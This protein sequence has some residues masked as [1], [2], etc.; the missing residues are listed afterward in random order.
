M[1]RAMQASALPEISSLSPAQFEVLGYVS[2]KSDVSVKDIAQALKITPSA[3][4]QLVEPLVQEGCILR[5]TDPSDRRSV[6]LHISPV[7]KKELVTVNHAKVAWMSQILEPLSDEELI[8]LV[9]L[10]E[11]IT[12]NSKEIK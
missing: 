6:M 3:A 9:T 2:K 4:T 5:N 12:Q 1:K 11:K 7:G 8:T 10:L